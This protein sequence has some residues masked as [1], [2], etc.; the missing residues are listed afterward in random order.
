MTDLSLYPWQTKALAEW[1]KHRCRGMI[2]AVTGSGKTR[3]ALA[4]WNQLW[5]QLRMKSKALNTLVVVPTIPLMNQWHEC[6]F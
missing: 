2:E 3:V 5:H 6:F 1:E 4:A